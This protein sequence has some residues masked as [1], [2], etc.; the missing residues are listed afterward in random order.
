[1]SATTNQ[2]LLATIAAAIVLGAAWILKLNSTMKQ[3]PPEMLA[4]SPHRWTEEEMRDTYQHIK[5]NPIDWAQHLPP[6]LDRRYIVT[7]GSGGVG[8]QIVLHLLARGHPPSSIRIVD[9]R[10]P[11]RAD[12]SQGPAKLVGFAQADITSIPATSAAL[13]KPWPADVAHLP[14]TVFHTA[15]IIVPAERSRRTYDRVKRV[16]I[17]GLRN[18]LSASREAGASVFVSTSSASVAYRPVGFWGNPLRRWPRRYWQIVDEADFDAPLRPHADFFS[19]YAHTKAVGERVVAEADEPGFRTGMVRPANGVYGC[20][21]GDQVVGWSLRAGTVPTWMRNVV[22]NFVS[23]GHVSLA[24]LLFEAALLEDE[25]VS[26][27]TTPKCAGRPF[28]VTDAGPPPMYDDVYNLLKATAETR[29]I[30]P[31]YLQPG[32]M[33]AVSYVVEWIDLV[34]RMPVL[35]W[36]VPR[37]TGDL[38]MLQPAVFTAGTH[39]LASDAAARRSIDNGGIGY[40]PIHNSLEGMCQQVLEF[41]I[42][43]QGYGRQDKQSSRQTLVEGVKNMGSTSAAVGV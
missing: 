37:P 8:G 15:A 3:T 11:F 19:N 39:Y 40:K 4:A 1:M 16:N 20:S 14:L 21:D 13:S 24:H 36:I 35:R 43:H 32:I 38:A 12:M 2:V 33:L 17:D 26:S 10:T 5:A 41:N 25:S 28:T 23:V 34:S 7:G 30:V 27:G 9:F 22:Q 6:K 42:E 18:V 29:P 31:V